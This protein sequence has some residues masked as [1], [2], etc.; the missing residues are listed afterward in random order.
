MDNFLVKFLSFYKN[1][2]KR[3]NGKRLKW[4][5]IAKKMPIFGDF[6]KSLVK[7]C[8]L[9]ENGTLVDF[10]LE[11]YF[12]HAQLSNKKKIGTKDP[13]TKKWHLV[14]VE[15]KS[16]KIDKNYTFSQYGGSRWGHVGFLTILSLLQEAAILWFLGLLFIFFFI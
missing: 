3:R 6:L 1:I 2:K 14:E 16:A 5:Q 15:A 13:E 12:L 11:S 8:N 7:H 4:G 9:A 10:F